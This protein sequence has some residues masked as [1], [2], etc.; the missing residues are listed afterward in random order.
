[1]FDVQLDY[2][3]NVYEFGY[4]MKICDG[5]DGNDGDVVSEVTSDK[6]DENSKA[7]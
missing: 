2:F 6:Y 5:T 3:D 7:I 4:E 1:M